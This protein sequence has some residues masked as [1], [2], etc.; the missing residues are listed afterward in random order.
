M[1]KCLSEQEILT[2]EDLRRNVLSKIVFSLS[3]LLYI[4]W[5]LY[6]LQTS[7]KSLQR[8]KKRNI[9]C[10]NTLIKIVW[11]PFTNDGDE[12]Y[13]IFYFVLK[14]SCVLFIFV[15]NI[16][17]IYLWKLKKNRLKQNRWNKTFKSIKL[18]NRGVRGN[19][20]ET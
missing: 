5:F 11:Q 7:V 12:I 18:K 20:W 14:L 8:I 3:W 16:F 2:V 1:F 19:Q 4:Y 17:L 13:C 6:S 9:W 10:F 15:R